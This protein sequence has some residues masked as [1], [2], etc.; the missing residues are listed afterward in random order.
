MDF[1][2]DINS[3]YE[4]DEVLALDKPSG[5]VVHGDGKTEEPTLVEWLLVQYPAIESVGESWEAPDGR[6][7]PRPG[8]VHRLDRET[9]G[10]MLVAKTQASFEHLKQQ[11]SAPSR[12]YARDERDL[13]EDGQDHSIEKTY[14]AFVHGMLKDET[15]IIDKPI[16]KSSKD[17]RK[18]S[19]QPG[20]RGTLRGAL[21]EYTVQKRLS[22]MTYV[23]VR[24]K[25]GRTHQI[26]V[27]FKAIHHP[28]VCDSLYA[29]KHDCM[30][31][32]RLA[33]HA[34]AIS[35]NA[36]SGERITVETPLPKEFA[37]ALKES[38]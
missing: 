20:A 2:Y 17:F 38:A 36:L 23:E 1:P 19:A 34:K 6:D 25:T 12:A 4:D 22:E 3:L 24:P 31:F 21:T 27:H 29:P 32:S 8:I 18:W 11:F 16:G 10:V 30:G 9:S 14:V 28:V 26:R 35:F 37:N 33:L 15:G 5:L 13:V 7:I